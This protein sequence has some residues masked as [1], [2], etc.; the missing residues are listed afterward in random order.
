MKILQ[1]LKQRNDSCAQWYSMSKANSDSYWQHEMTKQQIELELRLSRMNAAQA[2]NNYAATAVR[3]LLG[4]QGL[5]NL[6]S[7]TRKTSG[8]LPCI[9]KAWRPARQLAE[10]KEGRADAKNAL[11]NQTRRAI[12]AEK[13]SRNK[14]AQEISILMT[15][16]MAE[17]TATE[18][19]LRQ[20]YKDAF[21]FLKGDKA[22]YEHSPERQRTNEYAK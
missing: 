21:S 6:E 3:N 13:S 16:G 19:V 7:R 10:F 9:A 2:L 1:A 8:K 14:L 15:L 12:A 11:T 20:K 5:E 18:I 4:V 22:K 17:S